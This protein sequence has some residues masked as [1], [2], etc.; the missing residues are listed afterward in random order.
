MSRRLLD[1]FEVV[2]RVVTSPVVDWAAPSET[3]PLLVRPLLQTRSFAMCVL[4]GIVVSVGGMSIHVLKA[5]LEALLEAF[6]H[7]NSDKL[8]LARTLIAVA[9]KHEHSD[10]L[11]VPLLLTV[12]KLLNADLLDATV[13]TDIV[14]ILASELTF[15]SS[16]IQKM[17]PMVGVLGTLCR[18]PDIAARSQAWS[19]ALK[20]IASR[21]PKVRAKMGTDFYTA[22]LFVSSGGEGGLE[23]AMDHL[24]RNTWDDGNATKVRGARDALYGMLGVAR[25]GAATGEMKDE[26]AGAF[27]QQAVAKNYAHLVHE[28]GY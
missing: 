17:L 8:F 16:D 14:A 2:R 25:P 11:A 22:L 20:I 18:C 10:R 27:K 9:K 21:F 7:P 4:E 26:T 19:Q 3:F 24:A 28:A 15:F 23:A 1:D 6:R 12:D 5:A 13:F